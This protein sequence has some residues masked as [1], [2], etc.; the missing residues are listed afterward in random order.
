[1]YVTFALTV[2]LLYFLFEFIGVMISCTNVTDALFLPLVILPTVQP[3]LSVIIAHTRVHLPRFHACYCPS[4]TCTKFPLLGYWGLCNPMVLFSS[5]STF[6]VAIYKPAWKVL[7]HWSQAARI[8]LAIDQSSW[9]QI[10][11]LSPDMVQASILFTVF[12]LHPVT[13]S[14]YCPGGLTD[15]MPV[16]Q[17]I[18]VFINN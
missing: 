12:K 13:L 6:S 10:I 11:C 16:I 8:C 15:I 9:E 14:V 4:L 3:I 1:M 2:C 17:A 7:L 5:C 18:F